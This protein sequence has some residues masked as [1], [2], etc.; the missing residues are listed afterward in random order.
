MIK[1]SRGISII[2]DRISDKELERIYKAF[3]LKRDNKTSMRYEL[4][5]WIGKLY[6]LELQ[7]SIHKL[8]HLYTL[9]GDI[10]R[11]ILQ[12]ISNIKKLKILKFKMEE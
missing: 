6:P 7:K 3:N 11:H 4:S 1:D 10:K 12:D 5:F 9:K 2:E 8:T